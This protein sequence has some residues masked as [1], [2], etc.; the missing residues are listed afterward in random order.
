MSREE[1]EQMVQGGIGAGFEAREGLTERRSF[2]CGEDGDG[3]EGEGGGSLGDD[4]GLRWFAAA[5]E[6]KGVGL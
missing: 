2:R 1:G 4:E 5:G 6:R 3:M